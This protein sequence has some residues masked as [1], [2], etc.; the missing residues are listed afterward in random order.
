MVLICLGLTCVASHTLWV[1]V[2][3]CMLGVRRKV[4][5][6][7]PAVQ[8]PCLGKHMDGVCYTCTGRKAWQIP[9]DLHRDISGCT[10]HC[11]ADLVFSKTKR[12]Y[13]PYGDSQVWGC[14]YSSHPEVPELVVNI[15]L[16]YWKAK[17]SG[18]S[19]QCCH[20]HTAFH[21]KMLLVRKGFQIHNRTH[22][23]IKD[24]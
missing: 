11:M 14:K 9:T 5:E 22:S 21:F 24:L 15:P 19:I 3:I 10:A 6:S 12:V 4:T 18:A 13:V 7:M 8:Y 20:K 16:S 1:W 17:R 2:L 23:D